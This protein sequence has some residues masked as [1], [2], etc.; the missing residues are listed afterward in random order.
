MAHSQDP[1]RLYDDAPIA[2]IEITCRRDGALSV[3]GSIE[4]Q[5]YALAILANAADAIRNYHTR[6]RAQIIVPARDVSLP[7]K[8]IV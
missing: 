3:A 7:Q 1:D 2:R 6:R 4:H 5:E 8:V